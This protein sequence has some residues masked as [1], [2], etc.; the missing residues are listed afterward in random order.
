[1]VRYMPGDRMF[2]EVEDFLT[3]ERSGGGRDRQLCVVLVS[4]IAGSTQQLAA[5]GGDEW[6]RRLESHRRSVREA[7]RHHQGREIDT[8]GD[9]FLVT[10]SLASRAVACAAEML[11]AAHEE[12]IHVRIGLHT[13]EVTVRD[14]VVTGMAVHIAARVAAIAAPSQILMTDTVAAVLLG[15]TGAPLLEQPIEYELKG[16][17][18]VW[19][20]HPVIL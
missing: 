9:G 16:V 19:R 3:G 14:N 15:V 1:M 13:G 10:F 20:L 8:A 2:D 5:D 6:R 4:D 11:A 17:P 7:L 12:G 18:G